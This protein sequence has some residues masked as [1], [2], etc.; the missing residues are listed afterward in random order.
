VS[1]NYLLAGPAVGWGG[2]LDA[3]EC[4]PGSGGF[5]F[6]SLIFTRLKMLWRWRER[7]S[8]K[9]FLTILVAVRQCGTRFFRCCHGNAWKRGC[10]G[11]VK[12]ENARVTI[13]PTYHLFRRQRLPYISPCDGT[14]IIASLSSRMVRDRKIPHVHQ[15]VNAA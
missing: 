7:Y 10:C 11:E 13:S 8:L 2:V 14:H 12:E 1:R 3:G 6:G 4:V 9:F 5:G 15:N